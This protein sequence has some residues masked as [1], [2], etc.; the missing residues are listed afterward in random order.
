MDADGDGLL[1]KREVR[2][3]LAELGDRDNRPGLRPYQLQHL[4]DKIDLDG[5]GEVS[6][7]ELVEFLVAQ[8]GAM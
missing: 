7:A 2:D 5:D 4:F 8:A 1:T 3:A 6:Y